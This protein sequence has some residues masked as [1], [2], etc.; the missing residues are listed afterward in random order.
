MLSAMVLL[1]ACVEK[2]TPQPPETGEDF[3]LTVDGITKSECH[4]KVTPKDKEMTY[5]VQLATK[6]DIADFTTDE[7][8]IKDDIAYFKVLA[9][10]AQKTMEEWLAENLQKGDID[11]KQ[12]MLSAG[13]EYCLY[14]YGLTTESKATTKVYRHEFKTNI[15]EQADVTFKLD[16]TEVTKTSAT[17]KATAEPTTA[18]FFLNIIDEAAYQEFGG[19][20]SAFANQ[21]NFLVE[22]YLNMGASRK[23]IVKNL[24]S[25][26]EDSFTRNDLLPGEKYYAFVIGI[27]EEFN[28]NTAPV[29]KEITTKEVEPSDNKF[30][31]S[32][33]DVSFAGIE[34][35]INTS[36]NDGYLW[37]IQTMETC[38]TFA[39]DEE[40]MWSVA[41]IYKNNNVLEDYLKHGT[42]QITGINYLKP[43][44]EYY[45][46]VFGWDDAPTTALEKVP[47]ETLP[48]EED[49]ENLTVSISIDEMTYNSATVTT[50]GSSAV[51]YY[52]DIV[53]K[54]D[55]DSKV[56][57]AGNADEAVKELME[58]A[59]SWG[60]EFFGF[61]NAEYLA[62]MGIVGEQTYTYTSL[63]PETSYIVYAMSVN[64]ETGEA[65]AKK[66]FVSEVFTTPEQVVS[67]ASVTFIPGHHY[68]G[69][70][71]AAADP[72]KYGS[73]KG[74]AL[75]KYEIEPNASA[76][77]W[78]SNFYMGDLA[79]MDDEMLGDMLVTY[80]YESEFGNPDN[81]QLNRKS[82]TY[83]LSYNEL[84]SFVAIAKDADDVLG[85]GVIEPVQLYKED[86]SPIEEFINSQS[87]A[88]IRFADRKAVSKKQK[89]HRISVYSN[90][91]DN[92]KVAA[93]N[94]ELPYAINKDKDVQAIKMRTVR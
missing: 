89:P 62:E 74:F 13:T 66:A 24:G 1:F 49:P 90:A 75:L 20:E 51:Y 18:T 85:H 10:N 41:S 40:I 59:I 25:V 93:Y 4:I 26:G 46:L 21:V 87:E 57:S 84:Y 70:A 52:S 44:T 82:G 80:G 31:I 91:I 81:V 15:V 29:V 11:T 35:T 60:A 68:D 45:L 48:A 9:E 61:T 65:A 8:L 77:K 32:L 47:F 73:L 79:D 94:N 64:M 39:S 53:T 12:A 67:D 30:T 63:S 34:G 33:D 88:P 27:D 42:T 92:N 2:P 22:H 7:A 76:A 71:L 36:N 55:F 38:N 86:A 72:E 54:E 16:L 14:V 56:S 6:A 23:D 58:E 37:S 17:V 83:A 43:A 3:T 69:D 50:I 19:N 28:P 78:Y 5:V